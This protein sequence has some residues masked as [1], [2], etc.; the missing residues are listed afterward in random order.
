MEASKIPQ[1]IVGDLR[2]SIYEKGSMV[3]T[4]D[5]L[6]P[7]KKEGAVRIRNKYRFEGEI[8]G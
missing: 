6:W 4:T 8:H 5:C 3:E 2:G 1:D 7:Q